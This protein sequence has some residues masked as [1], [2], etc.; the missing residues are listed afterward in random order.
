ML[1]N[2]IP[3]KMKNASYKAM[4]CI[5]DIL[6]SNEYDDSRKIS[7]IRNVTNNWC[8]FLNS[9]KLLTHR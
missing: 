4:E 7:E 6:I 8:I 2:K 3:E 1:D 9:K 5:I